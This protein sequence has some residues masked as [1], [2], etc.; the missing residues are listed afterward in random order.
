MVDSRHCSIHSV[1]RP[2]QSFCDLFDLDVLFVAHHNNSA[3]GLREFLNAFL[4]GLHAFIHPTGDKGCMA[5]DMLVGLSAEARTRSACFPLE[6]KGFV[7]SDAHRPSQE[8]L[9]GLEFVEL[10]PQG[11]RRVLQERGPLRRPRCAPSS[12]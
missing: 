8:T 10:F 6:N 5:E 4:D 12:K 2:A 11:S 3:V 9:A 7:S 1:G